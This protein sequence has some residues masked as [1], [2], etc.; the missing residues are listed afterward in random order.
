MAR[1]ILP[2]SVLL[3]LP[4]LLALTGC[5]GAPRYHGPPPKV[6]QVRGGDTLYEIGR[7]FGLDHRKIG[8]WN[9]IDDPGS[10]QV[11]QK[12]RLRPPPERQKGGD[13]PVVA[14][15]RAGK[16]AVASGGSD[17]APADSG[18]SSASA[19]QGSAPGSWQWPVGG[20]VIRE[21][22][23]SGHNA[24][25]GIDIAAEEGTP[26]R[27]AAAGTVVYS[28][29]GLRG[30]G[31]LVIIRHGGGYLTTYAYNL[32][33]LVAEEDEIA[34]GDTVAKVGASG[35]AERASLHFEV[36]RQTDPIDP[37]EVLPAR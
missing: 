5:G 6:Y 7:R 33:N 34:A 2:Y 24:S 20:E 14:R 21:F 8:R 31:N 26:V 36:R 9:G 22:A 4:A 16:A 1:R 30:Y 13:V 19:P 37:R 29:D 3:V 35:A 17:P 25:N 27:A 12:L 11:G 32:K 10:L 28:G 15:P 18:H 23:T